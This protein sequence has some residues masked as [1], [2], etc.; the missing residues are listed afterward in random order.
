MTC[1]GYCHDSILRELRDRRAAQALIALGTL[2][3]LHRRQIQGMPTDDRAWR[4]AWLLAGSIAVRT[5]D[6][7]A[8]ETPQL[9]E[10]PHHPPEH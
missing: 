4:D 10:A 2:V 5:P 6:V 8:A 7:R 9:N 3:A 1:L